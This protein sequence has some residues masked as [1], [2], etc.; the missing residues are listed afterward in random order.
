M[1][2]GRSRSHRWRCLAA[3]FLPRRRR[4][5][6]SRGWASFSRTG[7]CRSEGP[8]LV[9]QRLP[10]FLSS[11]PRRS[12]GAGGIPFGAGE[13]APMVGDVS[14]QLTSSLS[15]CRSVSLSFYYLLTP[16]DGDGVTVRSC[17]PPRPP[18]GNGKHVQFTGEWG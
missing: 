16:G 18:Y 17:P 14:D 11:Q 3:L 12:W 10:A 9:L 13:K 7:W 8:A 15:A 2:E 4:R 1:A 6:L 5:S